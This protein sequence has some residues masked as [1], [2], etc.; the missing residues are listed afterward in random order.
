MKEE[1]SSFSKY[2]QFTVR[3]PVS[4][5]H[6]YPTIGLWFKVETLVT[7]RDI[8]MPAIRNIL[9]THP[10]PYSHIDF[11]FLIIIML[12]MGRAFF[13]RPYKASIHSK[14]C[15]MWHRLQ[16]LGHDS[17]TSL[18]D[19]KKACITKEHFIWMS[20]FP[21]WKGSSKSPS[22]HP[23]LNNLKNIPQIPMSLFPRWINACLCAC[24]TESGHFIPFVH[25]GKGRHLLAVKNL[26]E[27]TA[28]TVL[29]PAAACF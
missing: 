15:V 16:H 12:E 14:G 20:R 2:K 4:T 6:R 25:Y 27:T 17:T 9:N 24:L 18:T 23:Q 22:F 11:N 26:Q 13:F 8:Q 29:G 28:L 1:I 3:V 19:C 7:F 5:K 10:V 21:R